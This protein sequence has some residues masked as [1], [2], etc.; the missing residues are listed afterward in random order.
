MIRDEFNNGWQFWG[1]NDVFGGKKKV[2]GIQLWPEPKDISGGYD[3]GDRVTSHI[4]DFSLKKSD[5]GLGNTCNWTH[6]P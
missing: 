3:L 4:T 5:I 1:Y 2:I 6:L